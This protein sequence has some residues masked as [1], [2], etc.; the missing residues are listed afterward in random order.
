MNQATVNELAWPP[1]RFSARK[2]QI[3]TD[4]QESAL[5]QTFLRATRQMDTVSQLYGPFQQ[6][7]QELPPPQPQSPEQLRSLLRRCSE[8]VAD[9]GTVRSDVTTARQSAAWAYVSY[10]A[11]VHYGDQVQAIAPWDRSKVIIFHCC[12]ISVDEPLDTN[13]LVPADVRLLG[14]AAR[15]D[16]SP[17]KVL[18]GATDLFSDDWKLVGRAQPKWAEALGKFR[19]DLQ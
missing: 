12:E 7:D 15:K 10:V 11:D 3:D 1:L 13:E 17:A 9:Y 14:P 5:W 4:E 19:A 6:L 2:P 8:L 16:G 18:Y